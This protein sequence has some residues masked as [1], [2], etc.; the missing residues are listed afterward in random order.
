[1]K[2][3][4]SLYLEIQPTSIHKSCKYF[5]GPGSNFKFVAIGLMFYES[6]CSNFST[7]YISPWALLD[8]PVVWFCPGQVCE[9]YNV[10]YNRT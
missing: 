2:K 3:L 6:N 9:K 8:L 5:I 7:I 1:M 10:L 4:P